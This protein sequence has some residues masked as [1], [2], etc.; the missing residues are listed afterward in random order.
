[1][2]VRC[3]C[4][5]LWLL[6][7]IPMAV[8]DEVRIADL[9]SMS[10]SQFENLPAV[11][12]RAKVTALGE[13]I[14][15]PSSSFGSIVVEDDSG[16]MWVSINRAAQ[17]EILETT[18]GAIDQLKIGM[19][20]ELRGHVA[21]GGF[22]PVMLPVTLTVIEHSELPIARSADLERLMRGGDYLRLVTA[23]GVV[24]SVTVHGI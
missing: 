6:I 19:V 21:D 17:A 18:R 8:G 10:A 5:L 1:M 9:L 2:F 4:L 13:G 16:A 22:A 11:S 12:I 14:A 3:L 24:Q 23:Q 7:D 15:T 20:V